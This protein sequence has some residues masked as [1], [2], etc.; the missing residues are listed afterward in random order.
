MTY[1]FD[2]RAGYLKMGW[3]TNPDTGTTTGF[4]APG[5]YGWMTSMAPVLVFD[6]ATGAMATGCGGVDG[7]WYIHDSGGVMPPAGFKDG[8]LQLPDALGLDG[9]GM[10]QHLGGTWYHFGDSAVR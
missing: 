2:V 10:R 7:Q 6:P 4:L 5:Q 3:V 8:A 1:R 9:H